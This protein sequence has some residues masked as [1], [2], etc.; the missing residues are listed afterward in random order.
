MTFKYII[1]GGVWSNIPTSLGTYKS[2]E[3][4][5]VVQHRVQNQFK[6]QVLTIVIFLIEYCVNFSLVFMDWHKKCL[7][8]F[9]MRQCCRFV[10]RS[11][12]SPVPDP[13]ICSCEDQH[14]CDD[15]VPA[16]NSQVERSLSVVIRHIQELLVRTHSDESAHWFLISVESCYV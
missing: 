13:N 4:S 10:Q 3:I 12:P 8:T 1:L 5:S 9:D 11:V 2:N 16:H 14:A 15:R 7:N 6:N